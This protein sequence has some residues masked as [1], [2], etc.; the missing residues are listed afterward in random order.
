MPA[1]Q[2]T[3][4]E[5]RAKT[6]SV[7]PA[8][9]SPPPLITS[10]IPIIPP[11][12]KL[13][14]SSASRTPPSTTGRAITALPMPTPLT[15]SSALPAGESVLRRIVL[16]ALVHL[17]APGRLR[18]PPGRHVPRTRRTGSLRRFLAWCPASP[19]CSP[20]VGPRCLPRQ[21]TT[22]PGPTDEAQ[23]HHAGSR[24]ALPQ[25]QALPGGHRAGVQLHCSSS[26][27]AT[28]AMPTPGKRPSQEGT[29]GMPVEV[30]Q[31]DQRPGTCPGLLCRERPSG[32]A[33]PRPVPRP[34]RLAQAA[35]AAADSTDPAG[36]KGLGEGQRAHREAGRRPWSSCSR[37]E[38]LEALIEAVRHEMAIAE[39]LEQAKQRQEEGR[40]R[41][42]WRGRR[43][44][45]L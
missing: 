43:L 28:A 22:C 29:A 44:S 27:T 40:A 1:T 12:V 7:G 15:R 23:D 32:G 26:A 14:N 5:R 9:R 41:S 37:R 6:L 39:Q 20:R 16:A 2:P 25:R 33:Q 34:T 24:R 19:R 3:A 35:A 10:P 18:H 13:P 4:A 30:I 42:A 11:S 45:P 36:R 21:R 31:T 17:P 8:P 38:E